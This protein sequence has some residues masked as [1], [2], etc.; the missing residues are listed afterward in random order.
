M[1]EFPPP[2][3]RY[4]LAVTGLG[5]AALIGLVAVFGDGSLV[6]ANASLPLLC[7]LVVVGEIFPIKLPGGEGEFTVSTT[8]AFAVLLVAGPMP[9]ALAVALGSAATDILR[10][11]SIWRA[12]FNIAQYT[13]ALCAAGGVVMALTALPDG[14]GHFEPGDLPAI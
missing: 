2:L 9:A 8:F 6:S 5:L 1:A 14:H 13:L 12:A 10:G 7:L 11:R 3:R 4:L